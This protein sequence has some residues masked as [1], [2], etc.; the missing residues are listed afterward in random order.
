MMIDEVEN[1]VDQEADLE[2]IRQVI[3]PIVTVIKQILE[4][5]S[6]MDE[7]ID[8]LTRLVN[9]E[10]IGG[11]TN[12]YNKKSRLDGISSLGSKYGEIMNPYKDFYSELT[13]GRD[14]FEALFDELEDYKKSSPDMNDEV[15][16]SKVKELAEAL[17]QKME[18]MKSFG[19]SSEG[20]ISIAVESP[21]VKKIEEVGNGNSAII[22]KVKKMK[23][24]ADA[25][26]FRF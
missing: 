14:I 13:E 8:S 10:I 4:K 18:K 20:S 15:I 2:Q 6:M 25:K 3:E 23:A 12:L 7:E 16:E 24:D 11:I 21:E 22:E 17:H 5:L 26:G 19:G 1:H 9:D